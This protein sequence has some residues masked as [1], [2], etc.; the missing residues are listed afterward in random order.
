MTS[1]EPPP[2]PADD[3]LRAALLSLPLP[4][5]PPTI[6]RRVRHR[7]RRQQVR[8]T[9]LAALAAAALLAGLF[10]WRPWTEIA[11]RPAPLAQAAPLQPEELEVLFAP[12]PV[13]PLTILASRD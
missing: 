12:P 11:P 13:D 2:D 10:A 1:S 3:R 6:E 9:A 5:L 7:L 8:R 4:A